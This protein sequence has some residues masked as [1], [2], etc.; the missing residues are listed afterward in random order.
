MDAQQQEERRKESREGEGVIT[1]AEHKS[2]SLYVS[3]YF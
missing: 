3:A 2:R 1:F